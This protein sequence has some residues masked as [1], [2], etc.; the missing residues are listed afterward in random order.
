MLLRRLSQSLKEQNWTA[1]VIEFIL[2]VTGVFLGIQVSNWNS[3]RV[4][5]S[6]AHDYLGR[7]GNDLGADIANYQDRLRFW[8]DVSNYGA[9]GMA[10]AETGDANGATQWDLLLAYFQASQVAEFYVTDSTFE[11]L[12]SAG[13]LG[14]IKDTRFRDSLSQYYSLS[15]NP[16][17]TERPRYR[18]HVRGVIPLEVQKYIWT[19]CYSTSAEGVQKLLP[20][21]SP[22]DEKQTT[23]L[24]DAIRNDKTLMSE[25][26]YWMS[27][28][29]VAALY[30]NNQIKSASALRRL[31]DV[32][33]DGKTKEAS[34]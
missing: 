12:K 28:M 7:I 31:I 11:E 20:C 32:G 18:E 9:K 3:E 17:L 29:H 24:V 13:E 2:L 1:I 19:D 6:R 30:G 14:L 25:L 8:S 10:Y 21:Q 26:R 34:R 22:L 23:A 16:V 15:I 27:S 4:D 33:R 5:K